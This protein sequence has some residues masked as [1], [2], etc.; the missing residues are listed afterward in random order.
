VQA[1]GAEL[2]FRYPAARVVLAI[3]GWH[4]A[5]LTSDR[6][7]M[8][9]FLAATVVAVAFAIPVVAEPTTYKFKQSGDGWRGR[10]WTGVVVVVDGNIV[11]PRRTE[12]TSAFSAV[13]GSWAD[14]PA[15]A[16]R[17]C[18]GSAESFDS[19]GCITSQGS[20]IKIPEGES[21]KAYSYEFKYRYGDTVRQDGFSF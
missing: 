7:P 11:R 1:G 16:I 4:G 15:I 5:V 13:V 17:A 12:Q 2:P 6:K 18:K 21:V 9:N 14:Y 8:K 20:E 19:T 10:P 3:Y